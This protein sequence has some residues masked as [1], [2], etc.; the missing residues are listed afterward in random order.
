MTVV[1]TCVLT[2]LDVDFFLQAEDGIRD[3]ELRL[4][5]RR[6]LFRSQGKGTRKR[7][8]KKG[9][10]KGQGKGTRKRVKEKGQGKGKR[11]RDK[12]KG[13]GKWTKKRDKAK[14]QIG[15]ATCRERV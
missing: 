9:Q 5:F 8:K 13:Q 2:I 3:T 14:G 10:G 4:E 1:Y 15:R 12:E 11:K 6:V 7:D